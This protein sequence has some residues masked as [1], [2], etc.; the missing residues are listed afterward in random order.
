MMIFDEL[1]NYFDVDSVVWLCEFFKGYK[2]G[3]IVISYDVEFVGEMVNC[4]F[5]FDVNC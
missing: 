3:L 2:G 4:V 1:M 5:Y